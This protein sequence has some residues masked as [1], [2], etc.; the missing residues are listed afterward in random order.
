MGDKIELTLDRGSN[1]RVAVA[2][3]VRPDRRISVDVFVPLAVAHQS[4]VPFDKDQLVVCAPRLHLG[5]RVPGVISIPRI[6]LAG[7]P[8]VSHWLEN[9]R[10]TCRS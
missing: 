7:I 8:N 5:E 9:Y 2:M 1:R 4:A 3:D 6:D 10:I